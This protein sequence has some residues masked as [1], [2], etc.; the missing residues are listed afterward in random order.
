MK[1]EPLAIAGPEFALF[2]EEK[3]DLIPLCQSMAVEHQTFG[4]GVVEEIAPRRG[5]PP[6][7]SIHFSRSKKTSKFNLGAFKSGMIS[8]VGLP[9][10]LAGEFVT[11]QR[12]AERLKAERA[13]EEEAIQA[14]RARQRE[15]ARIAAEAEERLAF[16]RRRDLETRVGSLVSQAVSVSPHASALEYM[17]KLETAQLEH[18]R[19][20][21]PP[22]IEWLK[23]WAQ[24]IAKGE[25]GVEPAWSQ[26]QAAAAYLQERGITHL[27]HFTDFRNLQPICEAGGL[28]SYLALEALEGRT[29]WLQSDDESQRRDKSLGRQDSVRLSFVPNSFFFQ[30][31]HRHARLVWLRFSTAVLSLGD[32][33]YCHGN[34]A[35]DYSYVASR[36]DALGLDWDLLKSF[37][38]CRSPDGPPMSYPKRYASEWDDQERVRQEKKTINSEVL[39]K[40]FLSLDF[41]TGIFNALNGAQIQLI[42]T[43]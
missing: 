4:L 42:R 39:V 40:H 5:L 32:V 17:E 10:R 16:E 33:S 35:S 22:R 18:Y 26:G 27:W 20:A 38:G 1:T 12:E 3:G 41:C 28:L 9:V 7:L 14:E 36:P 29:V 37:S 30:R 2:S 13:A 25:T 23:E 21:L 34:A 11:W 8:V 6:L 15:A 19:R 24:R 31:V 43:E